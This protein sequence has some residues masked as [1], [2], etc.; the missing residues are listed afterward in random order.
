MSRSFTVAM[1]LAL[2]TAPAGQ[3]SGGGPSITWDASAGVPRVTLA[4]EWQIDNGA[5]WIRWSSDGTKLTALSRID[6]RMNVLDTNGSIQS[7]F[8]VPHPSTLNIP[9]NDHEVLEGGN[10]RLGTAFS[11]INLAAQRTIYR[12]F[13]PNPSAAGD[14]AV[15]VR[16]A[17]S[18]D[19]SVI[20]VGY[21]FPRDGQ[22]ISL[23]STADWR[24]LRTMKVPSERGGIARMRF[25]PDGTMLAYST[26]SGVVVIEAANG[27][28]IREIPVIAAGFTFSPDGTMLAAV[29]IKT[30]ESSVESIWDGMR[31]F[32]IADGAQIAS[33]SSPQHSSP[34]PVLCDPKGRF[35]AFFDGLDVVRLWNPTVYADNDVSIRLRPLPGGIALSPDGQ[36]LA[37]GNSDIKTVMGLPLGLDDFIDILR[38]DN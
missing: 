32:R 24:R 10:T 11:V 19:C 13:D 15:A 23:L 21:G 36:W 35:I 17:V 29:T 14:A 34:D 8:K 33:H 6:G 7:Q 12:E 3:A 20:A 25:S 1:V 2:A 4:H 22:T 38:I 26:G 18:P 5:S 31:V 37:I 30:S 16:L 9:I 27:A 28:V